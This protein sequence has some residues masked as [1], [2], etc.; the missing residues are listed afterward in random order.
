MER[1]LTQHPPERYTVVDL[2]ALMD[3][4]GFTSLE[5]L[6]Q[7]SRDWVNEVL[8]TTKPIR[9]N[10]WTDSLAVGRLEFVERVKDA[11][12]VRGFNRGIDRYSDLHFLKEPEILY[13]SNK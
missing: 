13:D 3:V 9:E 1:G 4:F 12:G 10:C 11:L 8:Q 7:S 5:Q 6:M 2:P